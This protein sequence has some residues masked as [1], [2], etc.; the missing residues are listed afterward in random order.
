MFGLRVCRAVFVQYLTGT[1]HA[2]IFVR[3]TI[4]TNI[5]VEVMQCIRQGGSRG[6]RMPQ[7]IMRRFHFTLR[8]TVS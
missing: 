1:I 8:N 5:A 4:H 7:S 2:S 6:D 3:L